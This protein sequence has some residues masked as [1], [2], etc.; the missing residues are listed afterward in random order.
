MYGLAY[1][2]IPTRFASLQAELDRTLAPFKRG[3]EGEFPLH[4]LAFDD[5]TDELKILHRARF[6][7]AAAS[8]L[9]FLDDAGA[10]PFHLR[11]W[12]EHMQACRLDRFEGTF[13]ELEPDF[14]AFV[15]A[16]TDCARYD[17]ATARY[18]RWLNPLGRWDW[19]ELG[20]RF[21]GAITGERRP[22]G[23]EP[24]ISSGPNIGRALIDNI[25]AGLGG[26][27]STEAAE[28]E[29]NVELVET[30]RAA[31]RG[32]ES[33]GLP[34]AVVL[35]AGCR[36]DADRWFDN[37][38][39]HEIGSGTRAVLGACADADYKT[40]VRAAYERFSDHAAAGVAYHS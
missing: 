13:A 39:W 40:L 21:N 30:L 15:R 20:G 37:I 18:G 6:R 12:S 16:F 8:G 23:A 22:A 7:F 17:Q 26:R 25:K 33:R 38:G 36:D 27:A 19:W 10:A 35:P 5:S 14:D 29:A 9:S 3:G 34:S 31:P 24:F 28:I 4:K 2:L 11:G 32:S 1:V